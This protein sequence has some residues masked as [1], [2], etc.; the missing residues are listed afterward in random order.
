MTHSALIVE[1]DPDLASIFAEALKSAGFETQVIGDGAM[2]QRRIRDLRPQIIILDLHLPHV[3]GSTLLSQIR[4]DPILKGT[5]V[6]VATADAVMGEAYRDTADIVLIKPISF[7]QLRDLSSR[8]RTVQ[9][10]PNPS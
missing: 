5:I 7:V 10:G 1:D 4:S 2:A 6:I 3:D 8:L 9:M